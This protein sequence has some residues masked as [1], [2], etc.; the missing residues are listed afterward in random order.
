MN[1]FQFLLNWSEVWALLIPL[2]VMLVFKPK[3]PDLKWLSLYTVSAFI[4]N[5]LAVF[6]IEY[7][8]LVPSWMN[9]RG[10]NIYY[11]LHSLVMVIFFSLY[12]IQTW[13]YRHTIILKIILAV[14]LVLVLC[15]FAFREPPYKLSTL[16]FTA[17]S[18]VLM[19]FCLLYFFHTILEEG[20]TNR[21][22]HPSFMV[23]A[24]VCLYQAITFF[25]FL[26]IYPMFDNAP[27]KDYSFAM[28]MMRIYQASF[29]VFCILL[30]IA[31]YRSRKPVIGKSEHPA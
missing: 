28:L 18:I 9:I 5:F 3:G 6:V 27:G 20:Q 7:Y 19:A 26:F 22:K 21:L 17:G 24:A 23:C 10:N 15:N 14:Y 12:I 13:K 8:D 16:H 4:L 1:L 11:N 2:I 30:A 25:I 31:L 29:V